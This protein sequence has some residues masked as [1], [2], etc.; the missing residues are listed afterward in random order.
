MPGENCCVPGCG[1]CRR[2]KGV[3]IFKLP[4]ENRHKQWRNEWLNVLT[5]YRVC[6][7]NFKNQIANDTVYT[8]EKHFLP[9]DTIIG[10][11]F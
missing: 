3:G 6:D 10:I 8:C 4:S 9:E 5:K 11:C 2:T 7:Q 1:T